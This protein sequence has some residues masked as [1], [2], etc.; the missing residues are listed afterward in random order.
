MSCTLGSTFS[1]GGGRNLLIYSAMGPNS[2][3]TAKARVHTIPLP[4]VK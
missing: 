3:L 4:V 2:N 1:S